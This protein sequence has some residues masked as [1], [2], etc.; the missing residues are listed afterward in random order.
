ML[1]P[2]KEPHQ[3][4]SSMIGDALARPER[5]FNCTLIVFLLAFALVFVLYLYLSF[6]LVYLHL[7]LYRFLYLNLY[8]YLYLPYRWKRFRWY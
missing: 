6:V 3:V 2:M 7:S 4:V 5:G 1:I 8:L